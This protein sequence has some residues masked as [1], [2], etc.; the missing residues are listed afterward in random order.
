MDKKQLLDTDYKIAYDF[1]TKAYQQFREVIKSIALFGSVSKDIPKKGSDIDVIVIVDD[2]TVLWD[3]ELIA[4]YREEL[5]KLITKQNYKKNLHINTVT[6]ST[7]WNQVKEGDPVAINVLRYGQPLIDYGGFFNP[8]KVLLRR[9][10][11]RPT[12]EAIYVALQRAPMHLTRSKYAI[13]GAVEGLYWAMVDSAHAALMMAGHTPPSP[14]HIYD[15]L[16]KVFSKKINRR[17]IEDFKEMYTLVHNITH[18]NIKT[19]EGKKIDEM[20]KKA[21]NFVNEM[22]L[23]VKKLE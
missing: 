19:I 21:E 22:K 3:E 9:G 14:E 16:N 11:I 2:C 13:L 8:L 4:W 12:P 1:A 6:L 23:L 18:G 7:F 15:M 5:A 10:K 17:L 20:Q